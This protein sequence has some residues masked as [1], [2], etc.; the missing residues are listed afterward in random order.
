MEGVAITGYPMA[1]GAAGGG[2]TDT[3]D[4]V[5]DFTASV[6]G[7]TLAITLG[8]TGTLGDLTQ[9]VTIPTG[10]SGFSLQQIQDAMVSFL[11]FGNNITDTYDDPNNVYNINSAV[12]NYANQIWAQP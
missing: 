4:Y 2:G 7:Q 8:R 3:N 10:S 9:S 12:N 5:D 1:G 11:N 6:S